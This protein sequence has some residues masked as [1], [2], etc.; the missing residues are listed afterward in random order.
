MNRLGAFVLALCVSLGAAAAADSPPWVTDE[1]LVED[2]W[3][4][5]H[6]SGILAVKNRRD[7]LEAALARASSVIDAANA[8]RPTRFVLTDGA[9]Q[10]L[11]GMIM[12]AADKANPGGQSV[13]L[14]NPYPQIAMVLGSYY[15]EIGRH[16]DAARVL[17]AGIASDKIMDIPGETAPILIGERANAL[18][19][20]KRF[21][22]ALAAYD[23]ALK[24]PQLSPP[25]QAHLLRGRGYTLTEMNRL[26]DAQK[27]YTDSLV[28]EPN[29]PT[30]LSELQYI[31]KVRGGAQAVPGELKPLQPPSQAAPEQ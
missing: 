4:D 11:A 5:I 10:S 22:E 12:A 27:A 3:A 14:P 16:E 26:D 31:A 6:A 25:L 20:L 28:L 15:N 23:D 29:N 17:E 24:Q 21:D 19:S 30:A 7:D 8:S 9:A 13:A 2:S 1:K 18:T